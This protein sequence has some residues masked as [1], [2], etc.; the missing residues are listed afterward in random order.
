MQSLQLR[1]LTGP[2]VRELVVVRVVV[3]LLLLVRVVLLLVPVLLVLVLVVLVV[4]VVLLV[5][6]VAW[7]LLSWALSLPRQLQSSAL[8]LAW[9]RARARVLQHR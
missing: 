1:W 3:L 8:S 9:A 5:L 4:L 2:L 6:L 7:Q